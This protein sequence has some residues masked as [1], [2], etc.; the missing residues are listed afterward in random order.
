MF[1]RISVQTMTAAT[2]STAAGDDARMMPIFECKTRGA[3]RGGGPKEPRARANDW[4]YKCRQC[5]ESTFLYI[6]YI[7]TCPAS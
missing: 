6:I 3:H 5:P 1:G 7:Y 4:K 2:R